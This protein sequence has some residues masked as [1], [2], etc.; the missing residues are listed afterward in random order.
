MSEVPTPSQDNSRPHASA[1]CGSPLDGPGATPATR[2]RP[3]FEKGDPRAKTAGRRGGRVTA[4]QRRAAGEP[5]RGSILDLM[6]AAGMTGDLWLPWRA[7]WKAVYALPMTP[8]ELALYQRHTRRAAP[9]S[10]PVEEAFMAVG[11]GAGK[12]RNAALNAVYRAITFDAAQVAPGEPVIVPLIAKDRKQARQAL[13]YVRGL[14]RL[15]D[16]APWVARATLSET[17]QLKTGVDIEIM[18][19][20]FRGSRGYTCPLAVCDEVAFWFDE[21]ANPDHEI[22]TAIRGTLGRVAGG[23]LLVLSSPYAPRG[24]LHAA[25]ERYYGRDEESARDHVLVWNADTHS[26]NPT[27]S[28]RAIAREF[29]RDPVSAAS[30]YGSDGFVQFRQGRQALFDEEPLRQAIAPDRRELPPASGLAYVAFVDAAEGARAGDSMTLAIAHQDGSRAVLDVVREVQPPFNP[31]E[32]IGQTFAPLLHAYGIRTVTG[33][34]HAVGFVADAFAKAGVTFTPTTLSKSDL[35]AELLP[36]INTGAVALLDHATLRTQLLTLERRSVRGGTDRIDHPR[37]G[38]DDVANAAAGALVLASG[39]AGKRK[40]R[41][42]FS[43]SYG[44][45]RGDPHTEMA[46]LIAHTKARL[47]REAEQDWD[48]T[49][50]SHHAHT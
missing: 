4:L 21:G 11:R 14:A 50:R 30:E 27:Y 36:L 7:F 48:R 33:D 40:K 8:E 22:L 12:T 19:A 43:G 38:H 32:V 17:I 18:T 31:G 20:S 25:V 6:D 16:I 23:L 13:G 47:A 44:A 24:E 15:P 39:V 10:A 9:P 41:V 3:P 46:D 5:Y 2:R 49:H 29:A 34:R 26:M 45:P 35:Y 42:A 1:A 37:G 28:A